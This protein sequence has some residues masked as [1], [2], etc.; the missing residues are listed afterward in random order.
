[1]RYARVGTWLAAIALVVA[2]CGTAIGGDPAGSQEATTTKAGE[3]AS[4][5]DVDPSAYFVELINSEADTKERLSGF[6]DEYNLEVFGEGYNDFVPEGE[7]PD[8]PPEPT[9][10]EMLEYQRGYWLG[11]FGIYLDGVDEIAALEV[12]VEFAKAHVAFVDSSR[13]FYGTLRD[14]V[15]QLTDLTEFEVLLTPLFD[16]L[17]PMPAEIGSLYAALGAAC[18]A[19]ESQGRDAGYAVDLDCPEPPAEVVTVDVEA[20]EVWS[21]S[22]NPLATGDGPVQIH[23][24]NTGSEPIRPVVLD[25]IDGDPL[26]LPVLNGLV[27]IEKGGTSDSSHTSFN[28]AYPGVEGFVDETGLIAQPPELAPGDSIVAAVW[29]SGPIVILDYRAG[30]FEVGAFVVIE[31]S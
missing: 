13:A 14:R 5:S 18:T 9:P 31:R 17:V 3:A 2:A 19:L 21:A 7:E 12:P 6:H 25:Q 30:Q 22:P 26:D 15:S 1:M 11:T 24:T 20:E 27:Q 4:S 29:G 16:P 10:E 23:I 8:P 28:L